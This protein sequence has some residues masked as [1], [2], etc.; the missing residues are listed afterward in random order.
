MNYSLSLAKPPVFN[1]TK[2]TINLKRY[3]WSNG[4]PVTAQDVMF[5]LNMMKAEPAQ[6]TA[7]TP[8]SRRT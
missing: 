6:T 1:G 2:V 5:W 3:M 4:T 8:G 7:P